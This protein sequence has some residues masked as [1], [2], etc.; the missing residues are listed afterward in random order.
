MNDITCYKVRILNRTCQRDALLKM[1]AI[2]TVM[3]SQ[4]DGRRVG[5]KCKE[6]KMHG[7]LGK[8]V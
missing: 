8:H 4:R 3:F 1:A 6:W 7:R 2:Q 5:R